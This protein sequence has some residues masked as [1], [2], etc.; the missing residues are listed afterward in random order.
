MWFVYNNEEKDCKDKSVI[1]S[2]KNLSTKL[3]KIDFFDYRDS[4]NGDIVKT[5]KD[6]KV[7]MIKGDFYDDYNFM[8]RGAQKI[9]L[10]DCG[11]ILAETMPG[12][13]SVVLDCGA[14]M[15][16]LTCFLARYVKKVYSM[17]HVK[18]HIEKTRK[19]AE[20]LGLKNIKFVEEDI[21]QKIPV[22]KKFDLITLDISE[23][24]KAL[25]VAENKLKVGGRLVSYCPQITQLKAFVDKARDM[26]MEIYGIK[27]VIE[28]RWEIEGEKT[29]PSHIG[30]MHTG[31]LAFIRKIYK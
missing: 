2:E 23:P 22:R 4:K 21:T 10:K 20:K 24:A 30:L 29:R 18:N 15:G 8:K 19:N 14:G 31:F 5:S 9:N 26:D 28:R 11:L 27:E 1:E 7:A 25:S 3:G 6:K 12:K 16:G 13:N 17:D